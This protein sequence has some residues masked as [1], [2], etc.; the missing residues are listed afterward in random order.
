MCPMQI[1]PWNM[2]G[3]FNERS[4]GEID[5]KEEKSKLSVAVALREEK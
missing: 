5:G 4:E 2:S 3:K 1:S